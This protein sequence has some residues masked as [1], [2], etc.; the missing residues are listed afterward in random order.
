MKMSSGV[1]S[2][3]FAFFC[4]ARKISLSALAHRL[5]ERADRLLAADEERHHHVREHDDVPQR[6]ERTHAAPGGFGHAWR[7]CRPIAQS[8]APDE[9]RANCRRGLG[10]TE[11]SCA[12]TPSASAAERSETRRL[13]RADV[14]S[15]TAP[16]LSSTSSGSADSSRCTT[17]GRSRRVRPIH[18]GRRQRCRRRS[19]SPAMRAGGHQ[20]QPAQAQRDASS[21]GRPPRTER[22]P[23][24]PARRMRRAGGRESSLGRACESSGC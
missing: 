1:G 13:V 22:H 23:G 15:I 4:A 6:Q 12:W 7:S 21:R 20:R 24:D 5:F 9:R 2:L 17:I 18:H 16:A 8:Y 10:A 3:V 11:S 19:S 14:A